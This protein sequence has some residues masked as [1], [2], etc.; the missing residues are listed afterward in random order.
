MLSGAILAKRNKEINSNK[1]DLLKLFTSIGLYYG[2]KGLLI[3]YELWIFQLLLPLLLIIVMYYFFRASNF[4]IK[5]KYFRHKSV[6]SFIFYISNLTLDIYIVQ[7][8]CI[9]YAKNYSF[10]IG[11]FGAIV[12]IALL[13]ILLNYLSKQI[14]KFAYTKF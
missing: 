13:A 10:P 3:H 11:Y 9:N 7:F 5:K 6:Q 14:V 4:I 12:L 2:Y 8:V 1:Y